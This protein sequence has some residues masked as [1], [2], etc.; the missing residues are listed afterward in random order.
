MFPFPTR[1]AAERAWEKWTNRC[2]GAPRQVVL[3]LLAP[4]DVLDAH[5]FNGVDHDGDNAF[6]DHK[7]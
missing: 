3:A 2:G 1:E 6:L 4:N 7:E 5:D